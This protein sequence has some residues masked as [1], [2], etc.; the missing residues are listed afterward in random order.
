M[1][2][3]DRYAGGV[4]Y[5]WDS[6]APCTTPLSATN[7]GGTSPMYNRRLLERG[8][9]HDESKSQVLIASNQQWCHK[10]LPQLYSIH[11]IR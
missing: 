7:R 2:A 8:A 4:S 1:L 11:D 3:H 10:H 9:G 6:F 5:M